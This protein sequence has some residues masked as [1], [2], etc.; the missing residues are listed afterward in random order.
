MFCMV[1]ISGTPSDRAHDLGSASSIAGVDTPV[2][3]VLAVV[4]R[5][6]QASLPHPRSAPS[7]T[8][9]S[10]PPLRDPDDLQSS[11][12]QEPA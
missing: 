12:N 9:P 6:I 1:G 3:L 2:T 4:A 11:K 7:I 10:R 5:E 8:R